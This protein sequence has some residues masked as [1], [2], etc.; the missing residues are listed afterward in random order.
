VNQA[1][2][3]KIADAYLMRAIYE[4]IRRGVEPEVVEHA[5]LNHVVEDSV[6]PM[7][8]TYGKLLA[9]YAILVLALGR[10]VKEERARVPTCKDGKS[11]AAWAVEVL[12]QEVKRDCL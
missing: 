4:A 9:A 6:D 7:D 3:D 1:V 5:V 11:L 8:S 12:E 10:R 2:Y